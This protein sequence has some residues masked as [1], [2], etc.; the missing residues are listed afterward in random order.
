MTLDDLLNRT[1]DLLQHPEFK[2]FGA[3]QKHRYQM[4]KRNEEDIE[5]LRYLYK[6]T[7]TAPEQAKKAAKANAKRRQ[8]EKYN[9]LSKY[10]KR[11]TEIKRQESLTRY[12]NKLKSIKKDS[13]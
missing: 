5:L 6:G 2:N 13:F 3:L 11:L 1:I 7:I 12:R 9:R 4:E 10:I 8:D